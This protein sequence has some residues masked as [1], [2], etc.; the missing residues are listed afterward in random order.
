[1]C[2][3]LS[4]TCTPEERRV[5]VIFNQGYGEILHFI[6]LTDKLSDAQRRVY[7]HINMCAMQKGY[8]KAK[9]ETMAREL[10]LSVE[11]VREAIRK[12]I[13]FGLI[14]IEYEDGEKVYR[15][16]DIPTSFS[17]LD[18]VIV[19]PFRRRQVRKEVDRGE[20][21][22]PQKQAKPG[23]DP[24][25][26]NPAV[27]VYVEVTGY[28]PKAD[29]GLRS[30]IAQ[31]VKHL[32][33]WRQFLKERMDNGYG[34]YKLQSPAIFDEYVKWVRDK[35]ERQQS[36]QPGGNSHARNW[37]I[38]NEYRA[39]RLDIDASKFYYH[40]CSLWDA[41]P[42]D[43]QTLEAFYSLSEQ[44][45][46][47]IARGEEVVLQPRTLSTNSSETESRGLDISAQMSTHL[48]RIAR[49]EGRL[50]A[51]ESGE[52][53]VSRATAPPQEEREP[54]NQNPNAPTLESWWLN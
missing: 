33:N 12:L 47:K 5:R 15:L 36:E 41:L 39:D 52:E 31:N 45:F 23:R 17:G 40:I 44:E 43:E 48:E 38:G 50:S 14:A 35:N 30:K 34:G 8:S 51:S 42:P 32:D 16:L 25:M 27:R 2:H 28:A 13:A 29:N 9:P 19:L 10:N 3:L 4:V 11:Y 26:S 22:K 20:R 54:K 49:R 46:S 6:A 18:E 21:P 24:D 53:G 7:S 1:L 37:R